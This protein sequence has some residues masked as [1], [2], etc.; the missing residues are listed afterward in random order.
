[1]TTTS[2]QM[3]PIRRPGP[4]AWVQLVLSEIRMVVRDTSGLLVPLGLPLLILVMFGLGESQEPLPEF[5]GL[6][7][8][9]AYVVPISLSIVIAMIGVVNMPSFLATYRR[10]G[11]LRRLAV[12][13]AHPAMVLVAQVVTSVVQT[14]LG[15]GLALT[16]AAIGFG[17]NAPRHLGAAIG[18]L[19]LA[20][21]AMYALGMFVAAVSP[22][23]N[24]AV[25]IGIVLFFGM[26]ATGGMFGPVENLP[27][28]MARI[29]EVLPFGAGIQ[30]LQAAW[31]GE[32]VE[33][34]HLT[35]L[36]ATVVVASIVAAVLFRWE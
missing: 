7:A 6:T 20:S 8:L 32:H 17:L 5:G 13:P 16:V 14:I 23:P 29:G 25:A 3:P 31:I 35:S 10:T 18:V 21:A 12:T 30:A 22:T 19:A 15:I 34:L 26:G 28:V 33:L 36:G 9:D 1:M 2:T 27:D 24:S 11:V 4:D